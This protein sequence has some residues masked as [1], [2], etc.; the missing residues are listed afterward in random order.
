MCQLNLV[1]VKN[2]INK[3]IL[4]NNEYACFGENF[5]AFSPYVKGFCNCGSFVG[6]MSD[7]AGNSYLEIVN[8]LNSSELE[9]LNK[10]KTFMSKPDYKD[11]KRKYMA[12]KDKLANTLENFI[13]PLFDYEMEQHELLQTKYK[14]QELEKQMEL[15]YKNLDKKM[16]EIESTP[17]YKSAEAKFNNLTERNKL[18][19]ESIL[20]YLTKEDEESDRKA[21][22]LFMEFDNNIETLDAPEESLVIDNVIKRVQNKYENDYSVFLEYKQLFEKLLEN[23]ECILFCCIWDE[24]E[25]LSIEKEINISN[26]KI[27]DLASLEYNQILRICK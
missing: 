24:P 8:E 7:Y 14:G 17:E 26:L 15:L 6:A 23:E 25:K 1:F 9:R 3:E 22:G 4:K 13:S 20:Y 2:S 27:E 21:N 11:L 19:D 10:I 16:H 5:K 18:M 12:E